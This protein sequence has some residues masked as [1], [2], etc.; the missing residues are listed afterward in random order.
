MNDPAQEQTIDKETATQLKARLGTFITEGI[1]IPEEQ[2]PQFDKWLSQLTQQYND[3]QSE[4]SS[5][6]SKLWLV[7]Q[8][9][10]EDNLDKLQVKQLQP[11]E[12]NLETDTPIPLQETLGS[13]RKSPSR[14]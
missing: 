8:K 11:I 13:G 2:L 3:M 4:V 12:E 6:V 14:A 10:L 5:L 9:S 1:A 7:D